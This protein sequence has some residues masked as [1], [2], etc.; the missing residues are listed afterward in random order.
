MSL[1]ESA[2]VMLIKKASL[3]NWYAAAWM[4]ERWGRSGVPPGDETGLDTLVVIG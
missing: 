1:A 2:S 3:T 4:L